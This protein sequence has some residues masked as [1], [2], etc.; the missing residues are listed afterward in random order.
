MTAPNIKVNLY[1]VHGYRCHD[2]RNNTAIGSNN[3]LVYHTAGVGIIT[4][5]EQESYP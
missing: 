5:P 1:Q 4:A 2:T 3:L